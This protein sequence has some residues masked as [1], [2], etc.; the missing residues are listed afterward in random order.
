MSDE[1]NLFY[2]SAS[3][4]RFCVLT[5]LV[6]DGFTAVTDWFDRLA[7]SQLNWWSAAPRAC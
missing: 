1:N 2:F 7:A 6:A 3:E 5:V 4:Q